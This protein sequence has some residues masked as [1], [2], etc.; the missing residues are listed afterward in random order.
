MWSPSEARGRTRQLT[1]VRRSAGAAP[2]VSLCSETGHLGILFFRVGDR[3]MSLYA[4]ALCDNA[5]DAQQFVLED[6]MSL[7]YSFKLSRQRGRWV[8]P[9]HGNATEML[10]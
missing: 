8:A 10:R 3:F 9:I 5:A 2:N 4:L 6:T 1:A 7:C